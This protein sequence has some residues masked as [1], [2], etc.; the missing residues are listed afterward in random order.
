MNSFK[1]RRIVAGLTAALLVVAGGT[2]QA[3]TLYWDGGTTDIGTN[4]NGASQGGAGTWDTTILNWDQGAVL[5]HVAWV[6]GNNDTAVFGGTAGTVT[7]GTGITVG[8]LTFDAAGYIIASDTLTF[9]TAGSIAAN[10]NATISSVLAGSVAITKTG[11]GT[12]TLSG[13]NTY[14]GSTSIDSG[15]LTLSGAAG[16]ITAS[17][18][19]TLNGGNL[20]MTNAVGESAVNRVVDAAGITSNGGTITWTNPSAD[21]TANWAETLGVLSLTSGQTNIISTNAVTS[22][23]TQVLTLGSGS[24]THAASNTSTIAFGGTSL[25]ASTNVNNINVT[26]Q[27]T[28]AANQIIGPW[29][30]FG[31]SATAQT[32]YATYNINA[33]TANTRGIQGAGIAATAETTWTTAANSY[34]LSAAT[35]LTATRTIT[36]LRYSGAAAALGLGASTFDLATY[37]ILNGGSGVLTISTTGTGGV[38]TPTGGDNTFLNRLAENSNAFNILMAVASP[39]NLDLSSSTGANVP[40]AVLYGTG[41][42][43]YTG[44]LTPGGNTFRLGNFATSWGNSYQFTMSALTGASNSLVVSG[45][46]LIT[47]NSSSTYKGTTTVNPGASFRYDGT[48]DNIGGGAGVRDILVGDGAAIARSAGSVNNAFLQRLVETTNAFTIYMGNGS[49]GN[50]LDFSSGGAGANLPNASLAFYDSVGTGTFAYTGTI[51]PA[52]NTYRFGGPRAGNAINLNNANTLT[53]ARSLVVGGA[54]LNLNAAN[55]FS[56]D[57]LINAGTLRVATNLGAQ[58]STID[59]SGAGVINVTGATTPTFGGLKGS[60]SIRASLPMARRA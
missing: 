32:D 48:M 12:L 38:T 17:S 56:G 8:G 59:T 53:G 25:G 2:A 7:L 36:A 51:T 20:T 26:G 50:S 13:A 60:K 5:P 28:T 15:T 18:G 49:C 39:N 47:I 46:G 16:A 1:L 45:T 58:N 11:V 3:G 57:T 22:G 33:G 24:L 9:G 41:N 37:G 21:N 14:N 34:T 52:N 44:T 31:T 43:A 42:T 6:N 10:A 54:T 40:N 30:T 23:R 4:G 55:D 29:A 19:V 35:T 27:A